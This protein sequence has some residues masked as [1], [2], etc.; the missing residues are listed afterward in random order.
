MDWKMLTALLTCAVLTAGPATGDPVPPPVA[1]GDDTVDDVEVDDVEVEVDD[2]DDADAPA[3]GYT[4]EI[5]DEGTGAKQ[6]LADDLDAIAEKGVQTAV[7]EIDTDMK[8]SVGPQSQEVVSP[9]I[10]MVTKITPGERTEDG[11]LRVSFELTEMRAKERPG[12]QAGLANMMTMALKAMEG[13]KGSYTVLPNGAT[14]DVEVDV[15]A[16]VPAAQA[17][18]QIDQLRQSVKTMSIPLPDRAV[19]EGA[20]WRFAMPLASQG[21][22]LEYEGVVTLAGLEGDTMTLDIAM[23]QTAETPQN[24]TAQGQQMKLTAFT[25]SGSGTQA[26]DLG[27]LVPKSTIKTSGAMSMEQ[28][29]QSIDIEIEADTEVAAE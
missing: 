20:K 29:G 7:V 19:G 24:I 10:R 4:L 23:K 27:G 11:G 13:T 16:G 1:P 2:A 6:K 9:T 17:Q 26:V 5:V 25:M 18:Q 21:M 3:E 8:M 12:A 15:P 28:A 22:K 14:T